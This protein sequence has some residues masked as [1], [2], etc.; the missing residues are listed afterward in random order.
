[1]QVWVVDVGFAWMGTYY[2][3]CSFLLDF[4]KLPNCF[5]KWMYYFRLSPSPS[6][7]PH[8]SESLMMVVIV[9]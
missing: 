7:H 2:V 9:D 4:E 3:I 1:M 5:P 6:E 8:F